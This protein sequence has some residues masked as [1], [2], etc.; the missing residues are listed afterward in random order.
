V[1]TKAALPTANRE[2]KLGVWVR[3][4]LQNG[5]GRQ[6]D[7]HGV[8]GNKDTWEV[9]EARSLDCL[10]YR[11]AVKQSDVWGVGIRKVVSHQ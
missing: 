10:M 8:P 11:K 4:W 7:L 2:S 9:I 1:L 3:V 6:L 5:A